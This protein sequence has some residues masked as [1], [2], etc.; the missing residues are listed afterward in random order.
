[1]SE[2]QSRPTASRGRGSHRGGRAGFKGGR[3]AGKNTKGDTE[4]VPSSLE[5]QDEI[6]EVNIHRSNMSKLQLLFPKWTY[7]DVEYALKETEDDLESAIER[8][9]SGIEGCSLDF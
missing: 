5:E 3:G 1:M 8:I 6:G 7:E 4:N 2:A 9:T